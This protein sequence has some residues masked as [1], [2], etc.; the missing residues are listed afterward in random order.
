MDAANSPPNTTA[1]QV[2]HFSPA[3]TQQILAYAL[4]ISSMST[5]VNALNCHYQQN[6]LERVRNKFLISKHSGYVASC[7]TFP[8]WESVLHLKMHFCWCKSACGMVPQTLPK[9]YSLQ[10]NART[11]WHL[12]QFPINSESK[13]RT[14]EKYH[15]TYNYKYIP[16]SC[17]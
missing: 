14:A 1:S 17:K 9:T 10:Y 4:S 6:S 3:F 8:C 16:P 15:I 13:Y 7:D 5:H 11:W 12:P 2:T